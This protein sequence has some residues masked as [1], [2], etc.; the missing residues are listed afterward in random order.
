MFS[1]FMLQGSRIKVLMPSSRMGLVWKSGGLICGL[2]LLGGLAATARAQQTNPAEQTNP[3]AQTNPQPSPQPNGGEQTN[4]PPQQPLP[5]GTKV[6][7]DKSEYDAFTTASK[8]DDATARAEAMEAFVQQYP[9]SVAVTDA[10]EEA[11]SAW[12]SAGDSVKVL[13]IAKQL[14][15]IDSGNVRAMAIVVALDRV[16][17]T[18][19][20]SGALDELCL[21]STGGM[22][23]ISMW[24]KP[25]NM[26]DTE[27]AQLRKQME[28]IFDGA[29]GYCALR[30]RNF[31]QARDWL[32]RV[33]Q[34]N[35]TDLEDVYDLA[36][37]DLEMTPPDANGFWYCAKAMQL[38]KNAQ[39]A[40]AS[41]GVAGYCEHMYVA[42]H[43]G[44]DGWEEIV[45]A[46]A[47][48]KELPPDFAKAIKAAPVPPA[49]PAGANQK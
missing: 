42:Y 17:A 24:Q 31:S 13:E 10:L 39:V 7:Q 28:I 35:P 37:V 29:A 2:C 12:Q 8:I 5:P 11:M 19:G 40:D 30:E 46:S 34:I 33:F 27:F 3:P 23:L 48:Q 25:A 44:K 14:Q 47:T 15:A 22:R 20:D 36:I 49:A 26:P 45:T 21:E 18:Q 43:G 4:A 38:A 16:S 1:Q 6:I 41:G 32:T 9:K